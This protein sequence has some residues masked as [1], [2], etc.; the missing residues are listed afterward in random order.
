MAFS[1]SKSQVK[2]A[3]HMTEV[4]LKAG[5]QGEKLR[6]EKRKLAAWKYLEKQ[7]G[8]RETMTLPESVEARFNKE[9]SGK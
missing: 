3:I 7:L 5:L 4:R 9:Y 6:L 1:I 2:G 8:D